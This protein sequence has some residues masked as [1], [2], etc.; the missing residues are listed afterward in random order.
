MYIKEQT[1]SSYVKPER[2]GKR[3]RVRF[4]AL[5]FPQG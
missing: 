2:R 4:E 3:R 5:I 1:W